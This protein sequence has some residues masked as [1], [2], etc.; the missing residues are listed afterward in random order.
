MLQHPWTYQAMVHDLLKLTLN[1]VWVVSE[2]KE[3]DNIK[4]SI[5]DLDE[6]F[7]SFWRD[8]RGSQFP[9]MA[10]WFFLF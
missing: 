9:Q 6:D 4:E 10:G 5:F 8:H 3:K 7:D 2:N 1:R